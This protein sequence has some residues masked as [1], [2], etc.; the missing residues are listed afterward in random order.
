[1]GVGGNGASSSGGGN[2]NGG[3][4]QSDNDSPGG[5]PTPSSTSASPGSVTHTLQT[6]A[7]R[8]S[9]SAASGA[10]LAGTGSPLTGSSPGVGVRRLAEQFLNSISDDSPAVR[11]RRIGLG[12]H[13][14]TVTPSAHVPTLPTELKRDKSAATS[15]AASSTVVPAGEA[16]AGGEAAPK[17][18]VEGPKTPDQ[19]A[20]ASSSSGAPA[21][22]PD[23]S[24]APSPTSSPSSS[25]EW[26]Q[27]HA[28]ILKF[29]DSCAADS[30]R[31]KRL[32]EELVQRTQWSIRCVWPTAHVDLVGSVAAGV[33]LPKSDLDFVVRFPPSATPPPSYSY[34]TAAQSNAQGGAPGQAAAPTNYT[35]ST[36]LPVDP[37]AAQQDADGTSGSPP[38]TVQHFAQASTLIKLIGGRKKSKL[39]FRS[40]KIQVFKDINLIRLRDGCSGISM[41][42][43]VSWPGR[44]HVCGGSAC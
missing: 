11:P 36:P 12:K 26:A 34:A 8:S 32:R 1:M 44:A 43:W 17:E 4:P 41:D 28:D 6:Q 39:L 31:Q 16:A 15:A 40:T 25:E 24:A 14:T 29:S 23:A 3:T 9:A 13:A 42:L 5:T 38:P 21:A 37:S 35:Y 30:A 10:P 22:A 18:G 33:C 27:L 7:Q 20:A 2:G 19:S